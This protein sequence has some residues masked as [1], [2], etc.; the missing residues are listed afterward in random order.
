MLISGLDIRLLAKVDSAAIANN[1]FSIPNS[2]DGDGGIDVEEGDDDATKGFERRKGM[3]W[4]NLS[5]QPSDALQVVWSEDVCVVE[6][7]KE[8]GI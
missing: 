4:R 5:N 3:D 6:T 2:A 1:G 8:E 7:G